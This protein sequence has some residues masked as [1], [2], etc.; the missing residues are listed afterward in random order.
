[1]K[2][3]PMSQQI[4]ALNHS[5]GKRYFAFFMDQGT[6]KTYVGLAEA[7]R[8]FQQALIDC[9]IIIA[10]SGVH[11]NWLKREAPK[12]LS[13]DYV[14]FIWDGRYTKRIQADL[15]H[16]LNSKGTTPAKLLL[17]SF[18]VEAF[19]SRGNAEKVFA[20]FTRKLRCLVLLD[21]SSSIKTVSV[22]RTRNIIRL[23]RAVHYKRPLSGTPVTERPLDYYSQF[24]W[25]HPGLLGFDK[26]A[27]F[28]AYYAEWRTRVVPHPKDR[29]RTIEFKELK[30]YKN[31]DVLKRRVDAH[32]YTVLKEDCLDL[33]AKVYEVRP[34]L[35]G[36][37]QRALY[38]AAKKELVVKLETDS[39]MTLAHA[40]T[41]L[42]RLRQICGGFIKTDE[43]KEPARI[44]GSN[45]KLESLL[46]LLGEMSAETKVIIWAAFVP[47][48]E[49]IAE[50][51]GAK[52]CVCYYGEVEKEERSANIDRFMTDPA[53]RY[54]V[55]NAR[56]GKYGFT[57]TA[58]SQ[59][60]Y[61]SNEY[62][63]EARQQSED[64]VHRI[65]QVRSV[66]YTDL[67]ASRTI[68]QKIVDDLAGKKEM[69]SFFK[70]SG[71]PS[72]EALLRWLRDE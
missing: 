4:A 29:S 40:F 9:A 62:S 13:I 12:L 5:A 49:L 8:L 27:T 6:G 41:R 28:K 65:G 45:A 34:V 51:L 39:K 36:E 30:H 52:N 57:L 17:L 61:F 69:A 7:E 32:S 59:V 43:M 54:F 38:D 19:S 18:N 33:P 56:T 20:A 24:D 67:I 72:K 47:E 16:M 15:Q 26:F 14:P 35:L 3:T 37:R 23:C 60:V 68:D 21:E 66:T 22:Q 2:L 71:A 44:E 31:M 1:M 55:G 46:Q 50:A 58:A 64:R 63:A 11:E 53:C 42:V 25:M 10:P 48:I 70:T